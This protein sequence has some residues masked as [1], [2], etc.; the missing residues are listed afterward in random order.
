MGFHRT[1]SYEKY[2]TSFNYNGV[3]IEVDEYPFA[4]FVEI[5]GKEDIVKKTAIDI[6]FDL[7]KSLIKPCDTLFTEWRAKKGLSMKLHMLFGDYDK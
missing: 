6:G 2:R 1:T 7:S 5:E 3:K 4:T